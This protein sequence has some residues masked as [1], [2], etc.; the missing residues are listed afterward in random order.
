VL[1]VTSRALLGRG[2]DRY[3]YV[4][5][6]SQLKKT[7]VKVGIYG[8]TVSEVVS[9]LSSSDEVVLPSDKFELADGLRVA[10]IK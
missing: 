7:P 1:T 3:V 9:G 4:L 6:G 5:N 10:V 8:Y 2:E